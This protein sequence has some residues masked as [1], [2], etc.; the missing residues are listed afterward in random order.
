MD[1]SQL[2]EHISDCVQGLDRP[3]IVGINGAI[4]S[5][6]TMLA[7][8][9]NDHLQQAGIATL[10]LH[11][12]DFHNP[13]SVRMQDN[14]PA[15]YL[16]HAIDIEKFTG[17]IRAIRTGSAHETIPLINMGTDAYSDHSFQ[18]NAQTLVIV[19]GVYLYL[20]SLRPLFD[21]RMYL[22]IAHDEILRRGNLRDASRF[23]KAIL[24]QYHDLFIPAQHL[25][26]QQCAPQA[27]SHIVIDNNDVD[28]PRIIEMR[29]ESDA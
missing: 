7:D 1:R 5:G 21:F 14:T 9:L 4:T 16:Q 19:E 2:F 23:G 27:N 28:H 18:T 20:P 26:E 8:A 15:G 13:R 25:Y 10:L 22:D 17:L 29:I 3:T 6:K 11:I 24:D 12:D